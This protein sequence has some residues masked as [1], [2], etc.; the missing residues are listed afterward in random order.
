MAKNDFNIDYDFDK[1][2]SFDPKE[3][4][5]Y[6]QNASGDYGA[7][8]YYQNDA[9]GYTGGNLYDYDNPGSADGQ[10][11]D[12][13]YDPNAGYDYSQGGY[14]QD[15]QYDDPAA[16]LAAGEYDDEPYEPGQYSAQNYDDQGSYAQGGTY[17]D[18]AAYAQDGQSQYADESYDDQ[19]QYSEEPY[20]DQGQYA[21]ES[22]AEDGQYD[23]Q[24]DDQ[25][26][27]EEG[28]E[29]S[30]D[31]GEEGE[32]QGE[33]G[34]P[35]EN[36]N[37]DADSDEY[38]EDEE[39]PKKPRK[40]IQLPKVHFKK[41]QMPHFVGKFISL[42]FGPMIAEMSGMAPQNEGRRRR[43]KSRIFKEVYLPPLILFVSLVLV[44]SCVAG[45]ISTAVKGKHVHDEQARKESIASAEAADREQQANADI[46][47][48]AQRYAQEYDYDKAIEVLDSFEGKAPQEVQA[49]KAEY[50][51]A[52][53]KL[54]EWKDPAG[55]PN[56]SFQ[57]L[58]ADPARAFANQELGGKYNQN[59]VTTD[60]FQRILE[61]LYGNNYVLV[62][63][64]SFVE[65]S[66][67]LDGTDSCLSKP[68]Y[69]PEGK[70]PVMITETMVNY[71]P[72][73]IDGNGDGEPD[74]QGSGFAS[75]LVLDGAGDIKAEMVDKDGNTVVGDY[76]LVPILEV[77]LKQHPDFSYQGARAILAVT[78]EVGIFGYRINTSTISDKG[79]AYFEEQVGGATELVAALRAKGYTMASF[80][81][82]NR[83]YGQDNAT[84]IQEDMQKWSEQIT[85]V[86][87]PVN[88]MVFAR[89]GD[90][91]N[92]TDTKYKALYDKGFRIFVGKG[93]DPFADV[94]NAY[95]RQKR[96]MVTGVNMTFNAG[97]FNGLFDSAAV[98]SSVRPEVVK[99]K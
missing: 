93:D 75:K 26:A 71:Y 98:K 39:K 85:P 72:Y 82:A 38:Y 87:G 56:L 8:G 55:I 77:F 79:Q 4:L 57:L 64:D 6:D 74:A 62:D 36:E 3:N 49:Q 28:T 59:F 51:Q 68:I 17:D 12:Y 99:P 69:L 23:E 66:T 92:Y 44:I 76:D 25:Q 32:Y 15:G 29:A 50:V 18:Q 14:A 9:A 86:L 10:N 41:P 91:G 80:T 95:V 67:G 40:K 78:G 46:L 34:E 47:K 81:Y 5:D 84:Q 33:D 13:G 83:N 45:S 31:Y 20:D 89:E 58:I 70:K 24:Y 19:G 27:Y 94:T 88:V 61:A 35:V 21:D 43:S 73:M 16:F 90:I 7:D 65:I 54:V 22:Y 37:P 96:L 53:S 30:E 2:N 52:Q 97:M 63:F 48:R 1:E 42:Y 60:E 11:A